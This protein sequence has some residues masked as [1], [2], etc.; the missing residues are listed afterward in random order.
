MCSNATVS[1]LHPFLL[2]AYGR[3]KLTLELVTLSP[4][5]VGD[6]SGSFA[7]ATCLRCKTTHPG[8]FIEPQIMSHQVPYCQAC[9][10]FV[11]STVPHHLTS[12][13]SSVTDLLPFLTVHSISCPSRQPATYS[14]PNFLPPLHPTVNLV[15]CFIPTSPTL[16]P[17]ILPVSREP[18]S[19]AAL[20]NASNSRP[21][22]PSPRARSEERRER[23]M[24]GAETIALTMTM[25]KMLREGSGSLLSSR[26]V[27]APHGI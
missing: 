26:C 2:L 1:F 17:S 9:L 14:G 6:G 13:S 15:S 25:M 5:L 27:S 7:T 20:S 24:G 18:N 8:S 11:L 4:T 22:S 23:A 19:N 12:R 10:A 21:P 16:Q 3:G